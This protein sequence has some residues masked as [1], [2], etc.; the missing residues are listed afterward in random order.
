[1]DFR[2]LVGMVLFTSAF[3]LPGSLPGL[4]KNNERFTTSLAQRSSPS[5]PYQSPGWVP[6]GQS[7]EPQLS[8]ERTNG[9][10]V[11]GT[12]KAP[13]LPHFLSDSKD[14][15]EKRWDYPAPNMSNLGYDIPNTRV[16][17]HYDF[18]VSELDFA[19][20]GVTRSG[21]VVSHVVFERGS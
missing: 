9:K 3:A 1:M 20:D 10:S 14:S 21:M 6:H 11:L 4:P 13:K 7:L 15:K 8:Q 19:P 17:R 2:I 18:V 12:S 16:T 5:R